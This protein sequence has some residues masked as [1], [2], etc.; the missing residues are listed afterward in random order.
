MLRIIAHPHSGCKHLAAGH[1]VKDIPSYTVKQM[2]KFLELFRVRN[3]LLMCESSI[4][5]RAAYHADSKEYRQF[6]ETAS[7]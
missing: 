7:N 6:L 2:Q 3:K 1:G 5:M 4:S